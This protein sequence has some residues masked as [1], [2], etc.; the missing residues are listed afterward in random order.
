[1]RR[2]YFKPDAI[3]TTRT[4]AVIDIQ[5]QRSNDDDGAVFARHYLTLVATAECAVK[6]VWPHLSMY[7]QKT[8]SSARRPREPRNVNHPV[9]DVGAVAV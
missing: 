1:M 9:T 8:W 6:S 2:L 7:R 5:V 3:A 4:V